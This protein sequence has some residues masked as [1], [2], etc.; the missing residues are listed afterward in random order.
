[1]KSS[2]PETQHLQVTEIFHSLQGETS[3]S[4]L[5][6]A[7]IRLTGCNLR[8]HYCDSAYAFKGGTKKTIAEILE[9]L[10]PW[11]VKHVLLTGGEPLL[12]RPAPEL[13]RQLVK[14]GYQVSIETH[15]E[16]LP[17][18]IQAVSDHARIV[19]DIKTP[20]SGMSRGGWR[21]N[22]HSLLPSRDE[23]K[24][25]IASPEDYAF[26]RDI[27]RSELTSPEGKSLF[28]REILMSPVMRISSAPGT[29][30]GVDATW[31]AEQVIADQL[32]VRL[33]VQLHKILWGAE[34]TGV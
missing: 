6:F 29:V 21:K 26:A 12:Q 23:I 10:R 4:G 13:V 30:P 31:L 1:M 8:C 7:F 33:Q 34:R 18:A 24:F 14:E 22:I 3:L 19:M 15:G 9:I 32:P 5:R 16:T 25:V 20:S 17:H 28:S 27:I 2:A 11:K